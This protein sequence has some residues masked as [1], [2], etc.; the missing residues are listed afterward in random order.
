MCLWEIS[1]APFFFYKNTVDKSNPWIGFKLAATKSNRSA[2]GA[3]V[4]LFFDKGEQVQEI[5]GGSGFCAQNQ[6][7]LH[8]GLGKGAKIEKVLI[9]WPSGVK[10]TLTAAMLKLDQYN[11]V[12]EP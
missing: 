5:H 8:F 4:R 11:T 1:A 7:P 6:R 9:R 2:I 3:Q 12:T 10:Q